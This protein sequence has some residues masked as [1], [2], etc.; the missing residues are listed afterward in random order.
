MQPFIHLHVHSQ[1]S[2]LDGQASIPALVDKA[3]RD[4]MKGLA[5]TDHG[6]MFGIKEFF[7]LVKKKNGATKDAIKGVQKRIEAI[8]SGAEEAEDKEK[9]LASL[10]EEKAKLEAKIFKPIFGCEMYV[11]RRRLT[12][13]DATPREI[14]TAVVNEVDGFSIRRGAVD[15]GGYHLVVLA[16]NLKGY[17]NLVKLVS[18]GWTDGFYS[19]P[20]TDKY[21]LEKYHEGLIVCS[22]CLGGEIPRRILTGDI[23]GAEEAILWFKNIFG[24]DYYLELQRHKATVPRANHETYPLQQVVNDR[25]I[26]F[27]RKHGIKLVCTNDVHF[28]EEENAEAHDRLICL[29]TGKDLDDPNRMLYTKQEWLKTQQEMN[30]IFSDVPEAL[31]NTLEILDKVEFYS[32]D[33]PPLMPTFPIPENFGTEEEYRKK[34]TEEDLFNEFTRDENGNVVLDEAAAHK[35]IENLGGYDKLY[36]I[37]LEADYLK[38][39]TFKGA[40]ERYGEE[41]SDE[42]MERITFEL[43]IMKTMGFPGYFLIVQDFINAARRELDVSVGPGR[44]SAAGSVVAYCL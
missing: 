28:V 14:R 43:H 18:K 38:E 15:E 27:S 22:A 41:L 4:G 6:N 36:R 5:L 26:E 10:Q 25:L 19:R 42:I 16:K 2:I 1:Y 8:E 24:E 11:A 40:H 3:I 21:E 23:Q 29:S 17:H 34:F 31:S 44:G 12:D 33:H 20:R 39:L 9:E 35:K 32:I 30:D 13:K 7:N 37:K